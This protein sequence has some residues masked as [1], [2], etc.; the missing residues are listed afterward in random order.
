MARS[1]KGSKRSRRGSKRSRKGSKRT[2]RGSKRSRKGSKRSRK[3]SKK[4]RRGSKR[5]KR[6]ISK[7]PQARKAA[8]RK[9]FKSFFCKHGKN[10]YTNVWKYS[11]PKT[12]RTSLIR[13]S[14]SDLP[15]INDVKKNLKC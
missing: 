8:V 4:S 3:G 15:I 14:S 10:A 1:R 7:D 9:Y 2:R 6:S 5:S 13:I 12:K 11:N